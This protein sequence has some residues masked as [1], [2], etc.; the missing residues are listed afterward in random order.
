[1]KEF[2]HPCS[3]PRSSNAE[4]RYDIYYE[5]PFF[6]S[7]EAHEPDEYEARQEEDADLSIERK[8]KDRKGEARA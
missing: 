8:T 1:M 5:S 7:E 3:A 4:H 6:M 2:L